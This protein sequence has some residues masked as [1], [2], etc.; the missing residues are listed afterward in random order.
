M[1]ATIPGMRCPVFV[2]R[3]VELA[4][5]AEIFSR[6]A[7]SQGSTLGTRGP[8]QALPAIRFEA[9]DRGVGARAG[10]VGVAGTAEVPCRWLSA[11]GYAFLLTTRRLA[12]PVTRGA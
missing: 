4:A 8:R 11:A 1:H 9:R 10:S 6:A 7:G 2:G 5:L 12:R 3:D